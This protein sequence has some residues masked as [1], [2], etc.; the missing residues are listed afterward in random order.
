MNCPNCDIEM[1]KVEVVDDNGQD[2][3]IDNCDNCGA[4]WFDQ[5]ELYRVPTETGLKLDPVFFRTTV[6]GRLKCPRDNTNLAEFH[7]ANLPSSISL[8]RCLECRGI[9]LFRGQLHAYKDFQKQRLYKDLE[10]SKKS[11][12]ISAVVAVFFFLAF[13]LAVYSENIIKADT[14][15]FQLYKPVVEKFQLSTFLI[16]LGFMI[17]LMTG[18]LFRHSLYTKISFRKKKRG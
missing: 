6:P 4:F 13:L 5:N 8:H 2:F 16:F 10:F 12:R 11:V 9:F 17:L 15:H 1:S 14:I 18:I 3:E 7:D